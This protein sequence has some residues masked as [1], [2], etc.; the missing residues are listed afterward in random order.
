MPRLLLPLQAWLTFSTLLEAPGRLHR[1]PGRLSTRGRCEAFCEWRRTRRISRVSRSRR[2]LL[3]RRRC[4]ARFRPTLLRCRARARLSS[5]QCCSLLRPSH[6]RTLVRCKA[7][8]KW[9]T[10]RR[11]SRLSRPRRA[12]RR[13][14][15]RRCQARSPPTLLRQVPPRPRQQH[16]LL[17]PRLRLR[18]CRPRSWR[19]TTV[20]R[21]RPSGRL[22][23]PGRCR[24]FCESG[25]TGMLTRARAPRGTRARRRPRFRSRSLRTWGPGGTQPACRLRRCSGQ[26]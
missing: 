17:R 15:G 13:S 1:L 24:T 20:M 5:G 18:A 22:S 9:G 25:R 16:L 8:S 3:R 26:R 2:A 23:T 6:L 19:R 12:W 14:W 7:F 21:R 10:P 11:V 4:R